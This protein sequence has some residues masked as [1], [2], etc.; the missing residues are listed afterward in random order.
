MNQSWAG[1]CPELGRD[2]HYSWLSRLRDWSYL[3]WFHRLAYKR[4]QRTTRKS[5]AIIRL[6]RLVVQCELRGPT[7]P[8]VHLQAASSLLVHPEV[9]GP[10]FG[11]ARVS[12]DRQNRYQSRVELDSAASQNCILR[13]GVRSNLPAPPPNPPEYNSAIQQVKY[14]RSAAAA[15]AINRVGRPPES[16]QDQDRDQARETGSAHCKS[17][18]LLSLSLWVLV[19]ISPPAE[20]PDAPQPAPTPRPRS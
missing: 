16:D 7:T 14:P 9:G 6:S 11:R 15:K 1:G 18:R 12:S 17:P 3:Q 19:S 4:S 20:R 13:I 5:S 10:A 2:P 8:G